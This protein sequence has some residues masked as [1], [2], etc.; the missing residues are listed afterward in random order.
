MIKKIRTLALAS[1]L[2][3]TCAFAEGID[4]TVSG[5]AE[6]TYKTEKTGSTKNAFN[7]AEVNLYFDA[8]NKDGVEFHGGFVAFDGVEADTS[9]SAANTANMETAEAYVMAPLAG[10]KAKL[11]AGLKEDEEFG[12][13]AFWSA[14]AYWR[15]AI[16]FPINKNLNVRYVAKKLNENMSD[17]GQGDS[18]ANV[19]R[20]DANVGEFSLGARYGSI[21]KNKDLAT[22]QEITMTGA[23]V[24]GSAAGLD[25]AFE[26]VSQG[27]DADGQGIFLSVGKEMDTLSIGLAY[28]NLTDGQTGGGDFAVSEILDGN[29]D[30]S[31]TKD[32][33]ALVLP[34][35]YAINDK[36]S[37]NAVLVSADI[38]EDSATEVDVGL[39]YAMGEQTTLSAVYAKLSGDGATALFGDD[40]TV[41]AATVTVEF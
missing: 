28:A 4:L 6:I 37:A 34:I 5:D 35:S 40:Q 17:D 22:E 12:T 32:T 38:L 19:F 1:A 16:I 21:V 26:Y 39:E 27:D 36:L 20:I 9:T 13:E 18:D 24:T 11:I 8:T 25:L 3:G 31:A 33:S 23:Y 10:G 29:I 2:L 14:D 7:E 15:T 30:S 41:M